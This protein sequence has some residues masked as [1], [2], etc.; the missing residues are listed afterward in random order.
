MKYDTLAE[1]KEFIGYIFEVQ[2]P[3]DYYNSP[4]EAASVC[5]DECEGCM[6]EGL[7]E[8]IVYALIIGQQIN[9]YNNRIFIGQ[10]NIVLSAVEKALNKSSEL[11]LNEDE[12][13]EIIELARE[14]KE[15]L[16]KMVIEYDPFAK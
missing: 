10:Y 5:F 9:K 4:I 15:Q 6:A 7:T 1:V 12:K 2:M 8:Y 3:R 14:L 13:N 11:E 16:P